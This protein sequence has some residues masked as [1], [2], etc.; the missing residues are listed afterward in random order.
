M[1]KDQ[2]IEITHQKFLKTPQNVE[3]IYHRCR[4]KILNCIKI[5][6]ETMLNCIIR[7]A[8]G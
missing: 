6:D 5:K 1:M 8:F 4:K 7:K 2:K 3:D